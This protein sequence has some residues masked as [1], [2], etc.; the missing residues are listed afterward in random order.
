MPEQVADAVREE[1]R[2]HAVHDRRFGRSRH[3]A[4]HDEDARDR[5]VRLEVD[6][7]VV[8][9]RPHTLDQ[10]L[11]RGVE[12][13]DEVQELAR[14]RGVGAGDVAGI[15]GVLR[16]GVDQ[17]GF[18][19]GR[20]L[21]VEHLVVKDRRMPVEGDD[22][23]VGQLLLARARRSAIGEVNF[24]LRGTRPERL[25]RRPVGAHSG[26]RR[27]SHALDFIGRLGRPAVI[28]RPGDGRWVMVAEAL[29]GRCWLSQDG[30]PTL[31]GFA[32]EFGG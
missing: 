21:P 29:G 16:A 10:L 7:P 15:A 12:R 13:A 3:D 27:F 25:F 8:R 18:H 32:L 31:A 2:R 9:A 19:A 23:V 20:T 6:V 17:E 11:L 22:V 4:V 24:V 28:Q 30:P 14:L 26:D 5:A 1:H